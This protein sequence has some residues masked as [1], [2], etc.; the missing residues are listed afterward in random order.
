MITSN[1]AFYLKERPKRVL[2]IGGGYIGVEFAGI[3]NGYGSAVTVVIRRD[4]VLRGFDED[5]RTFLQAEL[6]K[7]GVAVETKS[8]VTRIVKNS[9]GALTCTLDTGKEIVVDLVMSAAGRVPKTDGLGFTEAGVKLDRRGK[10]IVNEWQ[11]TSVPNIFACGDCTPTLELTP[12]A[13]H[14][15]HCFADTQFGGKVRRADREFVATAVFSNPNM[16]SCGF[17]EEQARK[18]YG[19]IKVYKST[20]TPLKN[21]VSGATDKCLMKIIVA[22]HTDKVVGM[23]MVGH[24]AG[25]I[26][27]GFSVAMRLGVTKKQV[28][29]TIGIHPTSA[30]EF[31]TMRSVDHEIKDPPASS[32]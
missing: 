9:D 15:G 18:I 4:R 27:Q 6:L 22:S 28:D 31:V 11:Q 25:E 17:T 1:E 5:C 16:G 7:S 12:V 10:I 29:S 23:H 20:F 24:G 8:N 3:F 32:L 14:E 19:G 30:E 21:R 26:M 2:I 13:L